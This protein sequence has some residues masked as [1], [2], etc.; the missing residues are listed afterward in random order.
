MSKRASPAAIGAF[1][2]GALALAVVSLAL[3][4][5]GLLRANRQMFVLFFDSDVSGLRTGAPVKFRGVEVGSVQAVQL[6]L[7]VSTKG[8]TE[9]VRIPVI[10]S[11]DNDK[12]KEHGAEIRLQDPEVFKQ[13]ISAGLRGQLSIESIVT[14]VLYVR[15]DLFPGTQERYT[16]NTGV[17]YPQIPTV[18]TEFEQVQMRAS[19]F[20]GRL[21]KVDFEGLIRAIVGAANGIETLTT[22]M[23]LKNTI[24][25][26]G[27]TMHS[28]Q[29]TS[30]RLGK[31]IDNLDG[32]V[33]PLRTSLQESASQLDVTLRT[34]NT[35]LE[36]VQQSLG[37]DAPMWHDIQTAL[38][39]VSEAAQAV[40]ILADSIEH[41]P[42][43]L[44]RGKPIPQEKN[45]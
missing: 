24:E 5:S 17:N 25:S 4:G 9:S 14:G 43:G 6:N 41:N 16:F 29:A 33:V 40:R 35:A 1:V 39:D 21:D 8:H 23:E 38:R 30:D 32:Q 28:L 36:D 2:V 10:I 13:V 31:L 34:A 20:I 15:L 42:G 45:P 3:F 12:L 19:E 11:I 18:P 7:N 26:L 27:G 37:A 22:S 44:L